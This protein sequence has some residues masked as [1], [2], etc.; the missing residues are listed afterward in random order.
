LLVGGGKRLR[1]VLPA[2]LHA[3]FAVQRAKYTD[4]AKKW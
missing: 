2:D 4:D 3:R 1:D